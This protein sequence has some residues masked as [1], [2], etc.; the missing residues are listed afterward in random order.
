MHKLISEPAFERGVTLIELMVTVAILG[1]VTAIVI[2]AYHDYV[3]ESH[4]SVLKNNIETIGLLEKNY[5]LQHLTYVSGSYDPSN[6]NASNGLKTLIGWSP[7]TEQDTVTYVATCE[8][9]SSVSGNPQCARDTGYYV[10]ATDSDGTSVCV[11]FAG[12]ASCP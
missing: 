6:P 8:T 5:E 2:P 1:I 11:G 7:G 12:V 4:K 10:K 9:P 3:S